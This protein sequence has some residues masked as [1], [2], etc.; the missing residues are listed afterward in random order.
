[1]TLL[2]PLLDR[3]SLTGPDDQTDLE[4]LRGLSMAYPFVEWALLYVPHNEGAAR[5][6]TR[7]WRQAFFDAQLAGYSAV[8]LCG[9]LAFEE[10]LLGRLPSEILKADRLQLNINA[11]KREFSDEQVLEVYRR[12]LQLGPDLIL[13]YHVDS[14][15]VIQTFLNTLTKADLPRVHVLLDES[16][17]LG[18]APEHWRW[19]DELG[20]DVFVGFAGG[21]GPDNIAA[22]LTQLQRHGL[23]YW[24]DMESGLRTQNQFDTAKATC[25]LSAAADVR[26]PNA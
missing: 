12:A 15:A 3:V 26:Q 13:Q 11:R 2:R 17:G 23:R 19:P 8:H 14:T 9:S 4:D 7:A 1:M 16:R 10:L 18:K 22:V 24:P 20:T 5:N 21:L 6:P 25:V